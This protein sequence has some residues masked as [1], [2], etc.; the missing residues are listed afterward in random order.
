MLA[1]L[2]SP[3]DGEPWCE[4]G[5][6]SAPPNMREGICCSSPPFCCLPPRCLEEREEGVFIPS[7][8]PSLLCAGARADAFFFALVIVD[9]PEPVPDAGLVCLL[10]FSFAPS[11]PLCPTQLPAGQLAIWSSACWRSRSP[12]LDF[13]LPPPP[14]SPFKRISPFSPPLSSL[15]SWLASIT[16]PSIVWLDV[17]ISLCRSSDTSTSFSI[18]NHLV[19]DS[20]GTSCSVICTLATANKSS[21]TLVSD[22][23]MLPPGRRVR[24]SARRWTRLAE[25]GGIDPRHPS[26]TLVE[27]RKTSSVSDFP[28]TN[29]T[30]SSPTITVVDF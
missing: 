19:T 8:P 25:R 24:I 5:L 6:K 15:L 7:S 17:M 10:P 4:M 16:P 18:S 21:D 23:V 28:I 14:P 29:M 30:S 27:P 12:V 11:F 2:T 13:S 9:L 20:W 26:I 3:P 1:W 22:I